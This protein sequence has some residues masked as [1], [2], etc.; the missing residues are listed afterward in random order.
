METRFRPIAARH[1]L[2]DSRQV[3]DIIVEMAD[4]YPPPYAVINLQGSNKGPLNLQ[5]AFK[6]RSNWKSEF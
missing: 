2:P 4:P 1:L 5:L 6:C 3:V